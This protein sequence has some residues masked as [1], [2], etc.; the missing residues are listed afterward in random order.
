MAVA[1]GEEDSQTYWQHME[2]VVAAVVVEAQEDCPIFYLVVV[3]LRVH[4][5]VMLETI[6]TADN[7]Q[8]ADK[9]QTIIHIY[10]HY[11]HTLVSFHIQF[12]IALTLILFEMYALQ[13]N[14]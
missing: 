12:I 13:V 11:P 8:E 5:V 4:R 9:V 3:V 2:I 1:A 7:H 10:H 14:S 6:M